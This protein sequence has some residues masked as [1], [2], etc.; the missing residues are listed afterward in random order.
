FAVP[1]DPLV[2]ARSETFEDPFNEY[3]LPEAILRFRQGFGRLIRTQSDRGV[4]AILDRRVLTK[5]YGRAFLD[6]LPQCTVRVG[7]LDELPRAAAKWLNL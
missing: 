6:S 1:T 2:A 5:K 3:S 4:V 7:S